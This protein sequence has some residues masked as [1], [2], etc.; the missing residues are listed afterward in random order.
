MGTV[1]LCL[2]TLCLS[3]QV[4]RR[5]L[6]G[7]MDRSGGFEPVVTATARCFDDVQ[8]LEWVRTRNIG[9]TLS[10]DVMLRVPGNFTVQQSDELAAR[11]R[12]RLS[13]E[14]QDVDHALSVACCAA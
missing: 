9:H 10:V 13:Q 11:F 12:K 8:G 6:E 4:I 5:G 14:L 1:T 3:V 7:I 2:I